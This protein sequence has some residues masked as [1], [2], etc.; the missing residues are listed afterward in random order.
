VLD[1]D[2]VTVLDTDKIYYNIPTTDYLIHDGEHWNENNSM[3]T[4]AAGFFARA[5]ADK[6]EMQ[7][8]VQFE[9]DELTKA[10][11]GVTAT[12]T[13]DSAATEMLASFI[14]GGKYEVLEEEDVY[15][16]ERSL[17]EGYFSQ[18]D[19]TREKDTVYAILRNASA[20]NVINGKTEKHYE[21][22]YYDKT[23]PEGSTEAEGW[24]KTLDLSETGLKEATAGFVIQ[25]MNDG[26]TSASLKADVIGFD[27]SAF[28]VKDGENIIF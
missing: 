28:T 20:D 5:T 1:P 15:D 13:A 21:Y 24:T 27:T 2:E 3:P 10:I 4:A 9:K 26:S 19:T 14:S 22:W 18:D 23:I 7:N 17:N 11:A 16:E 8:L 6:A 25:A 12:A